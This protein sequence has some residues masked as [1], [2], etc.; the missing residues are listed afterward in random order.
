MANT[1][2]VTEWVAKEIAAPFY[3]SV[4]ALQ[5]ASMEYAQYFDKGR[6][7]FAP[8]DTVQIRLQPTYPVNSISASTS[9]ELTLATNNFQQKTIDLTVDD[10]IYTR[11]DL[12]AIE[13]QLD[14]GTDPDILKQQYIMPAVKAL[15]KEANNRI[16]NAFLQ[17]A[18]YQT[19]STSSA[20]NNQLTVGLADALM[21]DLNMPAE[22]Y[23]GLSSIDNTYL[24]S[25]LGS[26]F[27]RDV[28][29]EGVLMGL[30]NPQFNGFE[31]YRDTSIVEHTAGTASTDTGVTLGADIN[32]GDVTITLNGTTALNTVLP[33][34]AIVVDNEGYYWVSQ[35]D[36]LKIDPSEFPLTFIVVPYTQ[37]AANTEWDSGTQTYTSAGDGL[38]VQVSREVLTDLSNNF[39]YINAESNGG[40]IASGTALTITPSR[41]SNMCVAKGGL[42]IASPPI[43]KIVSSE[44]AIE[45]VNNLN[46]V[47]ARQGQ[48]EKLTNVNLVGFLFG[49]TVL[50]QYAVALNAG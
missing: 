15:K 42:A 38:V 14:L 46:I 43:E 17:A 44:F 9:G 27:Q 13:G 45:K 36:R 3:C 21:E 35:V 16:Y 8:G 12:N 31:V 4:P 40:V 47:V 29:D 41:R 34:D 1:F 22:R 50:P 19:G 5:Y 6:Q 2:S 48:L 32:D 49:V 25:A 33:G 28:S 39:A 10:F 18:Y 23:L 11:I 37:S 24:S 20:I 7:G 30:V 26:Y